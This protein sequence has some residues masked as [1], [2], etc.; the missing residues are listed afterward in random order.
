MAVNNTVSS[1]AA[2]KKKKKNKKKKTDSNAQNFDAD[3]DVDEDDID[4]DPLAD[5]SDGMTTD[6]SK[7]DL[8]GMS[9]G[10][11]NIQRV[12]FTIIL[13]NV[14]IF[15]DEGD[16]ITATVDEVSRR[17][18]YD[19]EKVRVC[20]MNMWDQDLEY[21]NPEAVIDQLSLQVNN[22]QEK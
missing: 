4:T 19:S 14:M 13:N 12:R 16:P 8:Q 6:P 10:T 5:N 22:S 3:I 1:N 20:V 17:T 15:C 18:G 7:Q 11:W 9:M 21:D 2:K